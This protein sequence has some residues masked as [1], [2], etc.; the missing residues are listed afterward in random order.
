VAD[1]ELAV[2]VRQGGGDEELSRC[3]HGDFP[4]GADDFTEPGR[5]SGWTLRAFR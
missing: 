5:P 1:V 2:R 4:E 3:G